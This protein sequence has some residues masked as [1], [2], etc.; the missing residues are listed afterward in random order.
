VSCVWHL[1]RDTVYLRLVCKDSRFRS[2][3]HRTQE[4]IFISR[5]H[6]SRVPSPASNAAPWR[7][8][9]TIQDVLIHTKLTS[10]FSKLLQRV[11]YRID[12]NKQGRQAARITRQL[13]SSASRPA[14]SLTPL[15]INLCIPDSRPDARLLYHIH[16]SPF[17]TG[18]LFDRDMAYSR[19]HA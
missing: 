5:P 9:I 15:V 7:L 3:L 14:T 11:Y 4:D 16:I 8:S 18:W 12:N 1:V 19:C 17:I 13:S 6:R 2:P 10:D